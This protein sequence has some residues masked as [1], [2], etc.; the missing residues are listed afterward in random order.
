VRPVLIVVGLVLAQDLS[1]MGLVPDQSAVQELA[2]AS[3]DPAFG[4]GVGPR[5]QQHLIQ[6]I[7]TDVCG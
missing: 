3:P 2:A 1:Q 7:G 5:R 4:D 6:M